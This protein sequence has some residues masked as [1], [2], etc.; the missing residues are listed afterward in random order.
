M[1][2]VSEV[3]SVLYEEKTP[4]QAVSDLMNRTLKAEFHG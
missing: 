3:Y 1:P 2:I 4:G